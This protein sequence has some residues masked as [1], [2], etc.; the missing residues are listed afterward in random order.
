M[1]KNP[2]IIAV[3]ISCSSW[4]GLAE[5]PSDSTTLSNIVFPPSVDFNEILDAN[6]SLDTTARPPIVFEEP[7]TLVSEFTETTTEVDAAEEVTTGR[8]SGTLEDLRVFM[9]YYLNHF[10][11][12]VHLKSKAEWEFQTNQTKESSETR[13]CYCRL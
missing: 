7:Y 5:E 1:W 13:V 2:E 8:P 12:W 10:R 3:F 6:L 11:R 4:I 9:D